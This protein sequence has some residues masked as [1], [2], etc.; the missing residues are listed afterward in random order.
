MIK[1]FIKNQ[2][3][4]YKYKHVSKQSINI[5]MIKIMSI[6]FILLPQ[7]FPILLKLG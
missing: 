4:S 6:N 7:I 3:D 1:A 5:L 2:I